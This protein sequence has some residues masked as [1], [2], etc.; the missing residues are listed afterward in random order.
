MSTAPAPAASGPGCFCAGDAAL[1]AEL[2]ALHGALAAGDRG[3]QREIDRR[4]YAAAAADGGWARGPCARVPLAW[5]YTA[6]EDTVQYLRMPD[7]LRVLA[8]GVAHQSWADGA[9]AMLVHNALPF[10]KRGRLFA[11][12]FGAGPLGDSVA[13]CCLGVL[14]GTLLG[15]YPDCAKHPIFSV[16][17]DA[18]VRLRALATG[19]PE[20]RDAFL[21]AVPSLLRL[22]LMEYLA[23]AVSDFC[24]G[25]VAQYLPAPAL[26]AF[27]A[28]CT[29]TCDGFRTEALQPRDGCWGWAALERQAGVL[30]DRLGRT[31]KARTTARLPPSSSARTLS[32]WRK[33]CAP[34]ARGA[35]LAAALAAPV[36][37]QPGSLRAV[38]A[39]ADADAGAATR[40]SVVEA[41]QVSVRCFT[42]PCNLVERVGPLL[43]APQRL[44]AASRV[45]VCLWCVSRPGASPLQQRLRLDMCSGVLS[46]A[47]C[48]ER[49]PV[50]AL[51]TLGR[52]L[53][54][55]AAYFYFC[56]GCQQLR[57]WKGEGT[58]FG[59]A[60][61]THR[62]TA[63][64]PAA[65]RTACAVCA[66]APAA[67]VLDVLDV[68][69]RR[70]ARV[71]LCHRHRVPAR[72]A[73]LVYDSVSLRRALAS[74]PGRARRGRADI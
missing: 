33:A 44:F 73:R 31:C 43:D 28:L 50:V 16:R 25:E 63:A 42:L 70:V 53:R 4:L 34:A 51:S 36:A 69:A 29:N 1:D 26:A 56:T 2:R 39:D 68:A 11:S 40:A 52:L 54:V 20:E 55:G 41:L 15:L 65:R 18:A 14:H 74:E 67:A 64:T 38:L 47:V 17:R 35:L 6:P 12:P 60:A 61:C 23:N 58:E 32:A 57:P 45:H 9:L 13:T 46:C 27:R 49:A 30:V 37:S 59:A 8:R 22:A 48:D 21:R 62:A 19:P 10:L 66:R 24:A 71:A 7:V 72:L 5:L 3:A